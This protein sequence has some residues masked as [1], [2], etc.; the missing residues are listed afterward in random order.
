MATLFKLM[1]KRKKKSKMKH[2]KYFLI[3]VSLMLVGY[4]LAIIMFGYPLIINIS[5]SKVQYYPNVKKGDIIKP[6][7]KFDFNKGE[8]VAY[9]FISKNDKNKYVNELFNGSK[10]KTNDIELLKQMQKHWKFIYT[11]GDIA[12]VESSIIICNNGKTVF[13]SSIVL[14]ENAQG[15]QS[16]DFGWIEASVPNMLVDQCRQFKRVYSPI[17]VLK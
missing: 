10:F 17:I 1:V 8:W 13:S 4:S 16:R 5:K 3:I 7:D 15:L 14:D 2:K 11:E 9:L 12:T 6:L